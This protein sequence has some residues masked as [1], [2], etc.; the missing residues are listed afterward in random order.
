M[1]KYALATHKTLAALCVAHEAEIE[2]LTD[3]IINLGYEPVINGCKPSI[4]LAKNART[5]LQDGK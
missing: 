5:L 2:R 4:D 3:I 1:N